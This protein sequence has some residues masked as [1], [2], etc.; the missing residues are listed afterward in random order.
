MTVLGAIALPKLP[1]ERLRGIA[2]I[3]DDTGLDELWLW[4]DCFWGG[5]IASLSAALAWT[6]RVRIGIGVLPVPMRNVALAAM[7]FAALHRL[8]PGRARIA[9]GHG[10]QDWMGQ[11]G[12]RVESPMTLLR[13]YLSAL[14]GLLA[15]QRVTTEGRYVRLDHVGLD[16]PP[17]T[18]PEIIVGTE[19]DR[20]LRLSGSLADA[21]ILT[22]SAAP[23]RIR[24]ARK[25]IDEG[26][27]RAG[28]TDEH[29]LIVYL[30]AA[31]GPDAAE[32]V[33]AQRRQYDMPAESGVAGDAS[34]IADAVRRW[35]EAG[36]DT[37]VLEPTE[38]DPDPEGFV[39]FAATEVR[40]LLD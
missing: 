34:A 23:D 4:E 39:R 26:R 1:P 36:A 38:A 21:T 20:S 19:G 24:Q 15:G 40:P 32:W 28:R 14:R 35:T 25:L 33:E 12:T 16:W 6:E 7:E 37:V 30:L 31:T 13:E 3:A 27:A 5:G 11:T 9:V 2:R 8:F 10:V 17:S 22:S 18:P 29:K